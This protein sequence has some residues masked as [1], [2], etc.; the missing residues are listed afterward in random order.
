[1]R[2]QRKLEIEKDKQEQ[3]R[4]GLMQAPAARGPSPPL[5]RGAHGWRTTG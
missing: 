1:M 3:I 2:R 5:A 4:L